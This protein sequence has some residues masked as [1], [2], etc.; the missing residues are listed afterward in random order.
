MISKIEEFVAKKKYINRN[1][2]LSCISLKYRCQEALGEKESTDP[3]RLRVN[4]TIKHKP[5][6]EKIDS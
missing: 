5:V 2:I 3:I 6:P 1:L 4:A